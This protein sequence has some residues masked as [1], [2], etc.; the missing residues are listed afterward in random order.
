MHRTGFANYAIR[1][2]T[3]APLIDAARGF[4][5]RHAPFDRMEG[6]VLEAL[7]PR[8]KSVEMAGQGRIAESEFVSGPKSV[9]IRFAM[10]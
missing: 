5:Q 7:V 9:P 2:V 8:L 4:L 3:P 6:A 10:H 1:M